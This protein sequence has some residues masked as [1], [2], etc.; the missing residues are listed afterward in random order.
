MRKKIV[1]GNWKMNIN[2]NETRTLIAGIHQEIESFQLQNTRVVISPSHINLSTALA[3]TKESIMEVA[4]QNMHQAKNGAFTGE[5]SADMLQSIGVQSVIIGH[6]ERREYF[7]ETN[8]V[9]AQ[10]VTTALENNLET[11]IRAHIIAEELLVVIANDSTEHY[12]DLLPLIKKAKLYAN[13]ITKP[14]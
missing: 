6:S 8:E 9:L 4:A 7:G 10:K 2:V 14:T 12:K 13:G 3:L 11:I 5:V 1:A